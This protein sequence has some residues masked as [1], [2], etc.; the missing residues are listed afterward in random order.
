MSA[1]SRTRRH[2]Q[3]VLQIEVDL[4]KRVVALD[5]KGHHGSS[6]LEESGII[7]VP[8]GLGWVFVDEHDTVAH[9]D[10]RLTRRAVGVDCDY[11]ERGSIIGRVQQKSGLIVNIR[12]VPVRSLLKVNGSVLPIDRE[13]ESSQNFIGDA[14]GIL[15]F[16]VTVAEFGDEAGHAHATQTHRVDAFEDRRGTVAVSS[17]G[18]H[19]VVGGM[20]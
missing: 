19:P 7:P 2:L 12:L 15:A 9:F 14:S 6:G 18:K 20:K 3:Y 10:V 11:N 4:L 16:V 17:A 1:R 5:G 8:V 13:S